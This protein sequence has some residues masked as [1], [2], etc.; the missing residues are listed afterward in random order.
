MLPAATDDS[1][2]NSN[3]I[4]LC[5]VERFWTEGEERGRHAFL[6]PS[7]PIFA[8]DTYNSFADICTPFHPTDVH[9]H[10]DVRLL[11]LVGA[12]NQRR[13]PCRAHP[14]SSYGVL[15]LG[16]PYFIYRFLLY[17]DG[18]EIESGK[19]SS[20]DGFYLVPLNLPIEARMSSNSVRILSLT[21]PGVKPDAV[22]EKNC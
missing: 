17:W 20:G 22:L 3:C 2:E 15:D 12:G 19:S 14:I 13:G 21:P 10:R 16:E 6:I 9:F 7:G 1:D 8:Q 4:R 5:L 18:F 11:R